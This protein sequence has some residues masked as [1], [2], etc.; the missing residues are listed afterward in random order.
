[1]S[2]P[3]RLFFW[4]PFVLF[5]F[6]RPFEQIRTGRKL[7]RMLGHVSNKPRVDCRVRIARVTPLHKENGRS[8][9]KTDARGREGEGGKGRGGGVCVEG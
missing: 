3:P 1:M 9:K 2:F 6:L 8:T 4:F 5:C 7:P